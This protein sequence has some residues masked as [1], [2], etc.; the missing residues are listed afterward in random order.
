MQLIC[1]FARV[2]QQCYVIPFYGKDVSM[3]IEVIREVF[4][5]PGGPFGPPP[6]QWRKT[7]YEHLFKKEA[8]MD[9]K[10]SMDG[11]RHNLADWVPPIKLV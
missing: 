10:F 1:D 4:R 11:L 9:G 6:N 7:D 5:L 2:F 3:K 8:K